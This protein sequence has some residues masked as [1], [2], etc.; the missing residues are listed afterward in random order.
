MAFPK[1]QKSGGRESSNAIPEFGPAIDFG[2]EKS[3]WCKRYYLSMARAAGVFFFF[4][5]SRVP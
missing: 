1:A 3:S 2:V 5:K 4:L